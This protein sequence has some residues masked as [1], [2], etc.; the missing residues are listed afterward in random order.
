MWKLI[1]KKGLL[2]NGKNKQIDVEKDG[3]IKKKNV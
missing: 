2:K 1:F 3:E